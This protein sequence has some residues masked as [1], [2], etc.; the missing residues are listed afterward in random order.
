MCSRITSYPGGD[1]RLISINSNKI[2]HILRGK[3][4][5][6][7]ISQNLLSAQSPQQTIFLV[8]SCLSKYSLGPWARDFMIQEGSILSNHMQKSLA[9]SKAPR[10]K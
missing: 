5:R 2:L 1:S 6:L 9:F 10:D 7:I 3:E 8:C 4:A